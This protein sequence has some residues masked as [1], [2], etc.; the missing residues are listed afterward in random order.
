MLRNCVGSR[1]RQF[2]NELPDSLDETY[3]RVLKGIPKTNQGYVRRLLQSVAVAIRPL[4]PEE[5]AQIL[6]F[7]PDG[8]KGQ[9]AMLDANSRP[10]DQEKE[11]LSVCPSLISIV[12]YPGSRVVQFSHFSVKEF[13][14]SD[15]LSASS[16]A[17]SHYHIILD[18]AHTTI[19]QASLGVLLR[20]DD[21]VDSSEARNIPL[22]TY[23]ASHWDYH[24]RVGGVSSRIMDAM[25]TLFDLDEPYIA[26]WYRMF[27]MDAKT[28]STNGR[29]PLYIAAICGLYDLV[30]HLVKKYPQQADEICGEHDLP[31]TIALRGGDIRIAELLLQHGA[32]VD[33]RGSGGQTTLHSAM[34][35]HMPK[36][37]LFEVVRVLLEHGADPNARQRD[38]RTPLLLVP[39][40]TYEV[41]EMLRHR[42]VDVNFWYVFGSLFRTRDQNPIMPTSFDCYWSTA[43]MYK[44]RTAWARPHCTECSKVPFPLNGF[45]VLYNY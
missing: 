21:R 44:W 45:P 6:T 7:D 2:V 18:D 23:A 16:E 24:A 43:R 3:E 37:A 10:G 35:W 36:D 34:G 41:R 11:L 17:I 9:D 39:D 15:R 27:G 14:T 40:W 19:A 12:E 5:L 33:G 22:A 4:R 13:L 8:N 30:E 28:R 32:T 25:K 29:T 42:R 31:L 20:L 38:L 26:A 1:V